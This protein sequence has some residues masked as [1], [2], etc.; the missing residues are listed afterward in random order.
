MPTPPLSPEKIKRAQELRRKGFTIREIADK[1]NISYG[2][3]SKACFGIGENVLKK[4]G[5]ETHKRVLDAAKDGGTM[6]DIAKRAKISRTVAAKYAAAPIPKE[7]E[8]LFIPNELPPARLEKYDPYTL[9]LPGQWG[10][11][12][13]IHIPSHDLTTVTLFVEECKRRKVVGVVLNG[14]ILDCHEISN[15]DKDPSALRYTQEIAA[16][17]SFLG[18]LRKELPNAEIIY[19]LGNHEE[20]LERYIAN[21]A[22]ALIDLEYIGYDKL[23][24][25]DELG[26]ELVT[27]KRI[28]H[29]GKLH[30]IHGHEYRGGGGVNPARW[31]YLRAGSVAM[32]GHFHRPSEHHDR[33]ISMS[34]KA[35][36]SLG[37]ACFLHPKYCPIN[38][39]AHGFAFVDVDGKGM[40]SVENK[41]VMNGKIV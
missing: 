31:L 4:Q 1:A 24:H 36:W 30:V 15:H 17:R 11:I 10:V 22:P 2:S 12:S 23:L 41:R 6:D 26:I 37:C 32:C 19:K 29:L 3:A 13:D 9:T 40:F 8:P 21:R 14:D 28:I 5:K 34:M 20:R 35:A 39:W 33:D 25:L 16:G 18:W 27:D 7:P 38:Q